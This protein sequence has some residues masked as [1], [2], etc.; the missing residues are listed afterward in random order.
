MGI[1]QFRV[2]WEGCVAH[3]TEWEREREN[4][5]E[6]MG[7]IGELQGKYYYENLDVY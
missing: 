3:I 6:E 2:Q 7:F 5:S 1:V 4:R